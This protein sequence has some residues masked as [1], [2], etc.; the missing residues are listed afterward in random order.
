MDQEILTQIW[1]QII[2]PIARLALFIT[3]G[4][5]IANFI[6]S[7]NWTHKLAVVVR[8][9]LRMSRLSAVTGA[10]FSVAFISGV[11]SNTMLAEAFDKGQMS[12]IEL[13]LANLFNTVPRFF[14]HLPTVFFLTAPMIRTGAFFYVGLTFAAA[15]LQT[16]LVVVCGRF[17]LPHREDSATLTLPKQAKITWGDAFTKSLKRLKKRIGK[18]LLFMIPVYILFFLLNKYGL[19]ARLEEYIATQAWFLAWLNPQSLGIVVLHVTTEFSAGLAAASVLLAENSL[20]TKEVVLALLV[21]N[22]LSTPIRAIRHQLPYYT[23][24]YS[25]QMALQLIGVSQV[26]RALCIVLVTVGY[27]YLV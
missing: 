5:F 24:I 8:P 11:S 10:S 17:L 12:R 14:L 21:G 3:I 9:L 19:F 16:V 23:G 22:I 4:L 1:P 2:L 25:P 13:F 6:E 18:V 20:T 27:F 7:L 26:V 15:I